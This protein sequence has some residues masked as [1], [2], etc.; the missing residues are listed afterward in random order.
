MLV[1]CSLV[2]RTTWRQAEPVFNSL[3]RL[4]PTPRAL[5]SA[6]TEDLYPLLRP[7][8]FG[9]RRTV[10]LMA[11]AQRWLELPPGHVK[12]QSLP[13]CGKYAADSWAIFVEGRTDVQATDKK[14]SWYIEQSR[15]KE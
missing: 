2:N 5:A 7:L 6:R 15:L 8:G 10:S 12:I 11:L 13:G 14:L 4:Y 3:L 9:R 1:A